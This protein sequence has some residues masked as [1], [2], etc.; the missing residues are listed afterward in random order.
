MTRTVIFDWDLAKAINYAPKNMPKPSFPATVFLD[1]GAEATKV[2]GNDPL[3]H[4]RI[5]DA[6]KAQFDL[7][8]PKLSVELQRADGVLRDAT[9]QQRKV[10]EGSFRSFAEQTTKS[11]EVGATREVERVIQSLKAERADYQR[12]QWH[13]GVKVGLGVLGAG[14]AG[15]ALASAAATGGLSLALT[16]VGA[17]R[18]IVDGVKTVINLRQEAETVGVRVHKSIAQ[19]SQSFS[20]ASRGG[21][22]AKE[23]FSSMMNAA[24]QV[25]MR[26]IPKTKADAE[27]W[28]QKLNGVRTLAHDLSLKLNKALLDADT[29]DKQLAAAPDAKSKALRAK[30]DKSATAVRGLLDVIPVNH[31]R[32]EDGLKAQALAKQS[33]DELER[34]S[35]Q[36]TQT[37]DK[38]FALA[39]NLGLAGVGYSVADAPQEMLDKVGTAISAINDF[40]TTVHDLRS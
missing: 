17:F 25:E 1:F 21:I 22:A 39:V 28:R 10:I 29:L 31:K 5:V 3:L 7:A 15:V 16:V 23:V 30:L 9:P 33:L 4:Q 11:A 20:T 14:A 12:Y 27:L 2:V 40:A 34:K 36:W 13:C 38:F 8:V 37:F 26:N 6:C 18:T 35:P 24:L 32:A 19:L